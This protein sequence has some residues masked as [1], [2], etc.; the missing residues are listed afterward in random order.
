MK[1]LVWGTGAIAKEYFEEINK[2]DVIGFIETIKSK[3][4]FGLKPVYGIDEIPKEYDYIVVAN[5]YGS[6]IYNEC[7]RRKMDLNKIIFA[8]PS[9][10]QLGLT[11]L[12]MLKEILSEKLYNLYC[13][14]FGYLEETWFENDKKTYMDLNVRTDFTLE[15]NNL[16][17]FL[18]DKYSKNGPTS[19]Y[20]FMDIWGAQLVRKSGVKQHFDI[21]SSV[22]GFIAHLLAMDIEVTVIDCREFSLEIEGMSAIVADATELKQIED[23]SVKSISALHSLEHFGLGRY[24][25]PIDPEACFKAFAAI[26]RKLQK[27]GNLYLAVPLGRNQLRFN[28][29]RYFH[30]ATIVECFDNLTLKEFSLATAERIVRNVDLDSYETPLDTAGVTGLFHFIK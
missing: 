24:G 20:F 2:D 21:G 5:V 6:E 1:L 3:D 10:A 28:G 25:D 4:T 23:N 13:A 22:N 12:K 30:P 8:V 16:L 29:A 11:D 19:A 17:P 18:E 26:Q 15:E 14:K 7:L 27:G 9:M